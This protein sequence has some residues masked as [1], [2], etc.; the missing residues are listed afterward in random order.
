M[1]EF[2]YLHKKK[3][4]LGT[5]VATVLLFSLGPK[6]F[7]A[8][9][10]SEPPAF[11]KL[12]MDEQEG[13]AEEN[14]GQASGEEAKEVAL[15]T[16]LIDIKG[17]VQ[18]P[19]VYELGKGERIIDAVGKAGGF[20]ESADTRKVNLA[21]LL[22]DEMVIY[23]PVEGE[24]VGELPLVEKPGSLDKDGGDGKVNIN[25]ATE[26]EL[27]TL[28]GIGPSK[29]KSII[30][31]REENGLFKSIDELLNVTGIGAKSLERMR[32]EITTAN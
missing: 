29:A 32:E 1:K 7:P 15:Q 23:V 19:G 22:V 25:T 11:Q 30:G 27:T 14:T 6:L 4:M 10:S 9:S 8:S 3:W 31:Y 18:L 12:V 21:A 26:E 13:E 28:T 17:A 24:D 2:L 5:I 20:L 16:V